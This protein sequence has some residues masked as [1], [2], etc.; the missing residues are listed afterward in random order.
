MPWPVSLNITPMK[1]LLGLLI[2]VTALLGCVRQDQSGSQYLKD[3]GNLIAR[4][5]RIEVV[6]HSSPMDFFDSNKG[7]LIASKEI[8]YRRVKLNA[9][10]KNGFK[11]AIEALPPKT[12]DAFPACIIEAHHRIEFYVAEEMID[13]M[14]VCFACGQVEWSGT[15]A[16]PP[17]SLYAGL[18]ALI[19]SVGM[20][21]KRDWAS[22]ASHP[23]Q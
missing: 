20:Q 17:W 1:T 9:Q 18:E 2:A 14:E 23:H 21:P 13:S 19:L 3:L 10:Q 5:D 15:K 16:T 6:E 22:L 7:E 8:S 4:A 12:Q 11:S